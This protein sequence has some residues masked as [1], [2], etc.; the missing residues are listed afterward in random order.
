MKMSWILF[1]LLGSANAMAASLPSILPDGW[2]NFTCDDIVVEKYD[3]PKE[4]EPAR[5]TPKGTDANGITRQLTRREGRSDFKTEG[6]T[7]TIKESYSFKSP[8][9]SGKSDEVTKRIVKPIG[10]NQFEEE[11]TYTSKTTIDNIQN[12]PTADTEIDTAKRTIAVQGD[13]EVNVKVKNGDE[14]EVPGIGETVVTKEA[15]GS[16]YT[17]T[18]YRRENV[19]QAE[20]HKSN[21]I[22]RPG[23]LVY[24]Y[25]SVCKYRFAGPILKGG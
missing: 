18:S 19:H 7:T 23:K 21:G 3:A 5:P 1:A 11:A 8:E 14:P 16:M 15:D 25:T 22:V 17:M 2:Y 6:D 24:Q 12:D 9:F 4:G 13:F 20:V 10:E